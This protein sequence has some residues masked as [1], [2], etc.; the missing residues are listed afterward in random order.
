MREATLLLAGAFAVFMTWRGYRRGALDTVASWLPSLAT[1]LVLVTLFWREP[2]HLSRRL[3]VSAIA[4]AVVFVLATLAV[5]AV[6]ARLQ[7]DDFT[8]DEAAKTR[9]WHWWCNHIAG[10]GLG[11]L[12]SATICLGIACLIS[13]L[14]FALSVQ[15]SADQKSDQEEMPLWV[16]SLSETARSLADV[17]ER[18]VLGHVP[19][20]REYGHEVRAVV[21]ILNAPPDDLKLLASRHGISDLEKLPVVQRALKDQQYAEQFLQLKEGDVGVMSTLLDSSITRDLISCPEIRELTK[22]LTPSALANDL[23]QTDSADSSRE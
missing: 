9:R 11:L 18:A 21:T 16:R 17:S 12:W 5:R 2:E 6:R 13:I 8:D 14:P 22:T 7:H 4:A 10:A 15:A 1:L 23:K 3:I 19:R 20:L